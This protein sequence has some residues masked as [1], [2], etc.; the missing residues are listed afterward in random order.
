MKFREI[1]KDKYNIEP[2]EYL[3]IARKRARQLKYNLGVNFADDGQHKLEY[4]NIL[5]GNV[6]NKDY[7]IYLL[8]EGKEKAEK[9]R[10]AYRARMFADK[11]GR[12][13]TKKM[14]LTGINW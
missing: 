8:T 9:M 4:D 11:P 14:R 2:S 1:L 7:I 12:T 5:F 10:R 3:D 6:D 13:I